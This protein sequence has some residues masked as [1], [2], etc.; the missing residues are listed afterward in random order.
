MEDVEGS[1]KH[2]NSY[3]INSPDNNLLTCNSSWI[4][5]NTYTSKLFS[6]QTFVL[7]YRIITSN[8]HNDIN[9][10]FIRKTTLFI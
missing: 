8:L 9:E 3:S 7:I 1:L 10:Y 6:K 2:E 4:Q 5:D